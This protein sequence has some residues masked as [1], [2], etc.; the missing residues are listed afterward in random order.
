MLNLERYET[1]RKTF[2]ELVEEKVKSAQNKGMSTVIFP[3][4]PESIIKDF[5]KLGYP[6][7]PNPENIGWI[8]TVL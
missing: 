2:E 7:K 3:H 8:V 1:A 6:V 5:Q 4:L